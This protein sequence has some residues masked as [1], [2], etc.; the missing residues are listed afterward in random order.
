MEP[1]QLSLFDGPDAA[2][3]A[4]AGPGARVPGETPPPLQA[5]PGPRPVPAPVPVPGTVPVP[6]GEA[7]A[8][9]HPRANREV[10]LPQ[11]RVAYEFRR[12]RR[13]T[14]GFV[15]GEEGLTVSAPRWVPLAEVEAALQ[16]KSRWI[17]RRLHEARERAQRMGAARVDWRDGTTLPYLGEPLVVVVD[18]RAGTAAGGVLLKAGGEPSLPGVAQRAL[19]VGLAH[20][21][22][23]AQ[24]RDAVQSWLKREALRVFEERCTHFVPRLGVRLTRLALSSAATRWGSASADGAIRLNWRLIHFALPVIDYVLVHELAHLR[25]MDHSP[26]FWDV[27]GSVVP[28]YREAR[29]HLRDPLLPI[30]D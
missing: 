8:F 22:Q 26:R 4:A 14:I 19:H 6:I 28:H 15:V 9:V 1:R 3:H 30:F 23:P 12:A 29:E 17:V 20:P 16:E 13:R 21:A 11:C 27:V 5:V 10:R 7:D 2:V 24:L 25:H 18:P